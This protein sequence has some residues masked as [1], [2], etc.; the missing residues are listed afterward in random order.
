[1][2]KTRLSSQNSQII[3]VTVQ[4]VIYEVVW[5]EWTFISKCMK[6][7]LSKAAICSPETNIQHQDPASVTACEH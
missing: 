6:K 5:S 1:M 7:I 2:F 3:L 4:T